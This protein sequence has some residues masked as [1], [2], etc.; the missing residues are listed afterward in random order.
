L[1]FSLKEQ[2]LGFSSSSKEK[3]ELFLDK[4][5]GEVIGECIFFE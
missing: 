5:R 2:L 4:E 3:M 1:I